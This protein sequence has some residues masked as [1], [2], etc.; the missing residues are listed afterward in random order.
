MQNST[1]FRSYFLIIIPGFSKLIELKCSTKYSL[2]W[3]QITSGVNGV[4]AV[5]P[6]AHT[7]VEDHKPHVERD[8]T[9]R[10]RHVLCICD[11]AN[12]QK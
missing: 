12:A 7:N 5:E 11:R 3:S 1:V 4:S 10:N 6:K 9:L 8:Q 2:P